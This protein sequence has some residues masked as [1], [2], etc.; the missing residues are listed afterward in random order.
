LVNHANDTINHI[1]QLKTAECYS[2]VR[3]SLRDKYVRCI[4]GLL[5]SITQDNSEKKISVSLDGNFQ[6]KRKIDKTS[7]AASSSS[8]FSYATTVSTLAIATNP[9]SS[10]SKGKANLFLPAKS[11]LCLWRT[12]EEVDKYDY[13]DAANKDNVNITLNCQMGN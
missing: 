4:L 2:C 1:Y 12:K 6:L 11:E 7:S 3:K 13:P 8:N 10:D 9:T 5:I